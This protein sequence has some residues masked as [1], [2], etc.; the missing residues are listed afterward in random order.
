MSYVREEG[1]A[2]I[3]KLVLSSPKMATLVLEDTFILLGPLRKYLLGI[4]F[5]KLT[6]L[7]MF[8]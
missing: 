3:L 6:L 7:I 5:T 4:Y 8:W 2:V 1:G